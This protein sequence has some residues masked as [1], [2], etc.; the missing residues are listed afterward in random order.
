MVS[1]LHLKFSLHFIVPYSAYHL[2]LLYCRIA[3]LLLTLCHQWKTSVLF[4]FV[5]VTYLVEVLIEGRDCVCLQVFQPGA[6]TETFC[7]WSAV[8]AEH[9]TADSQRDIRGMALKF[10]TEEGESGRYF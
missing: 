8:T 5:Y 10:Y 7:R 3:I 1:L 9:G 4:K 2:G 6:K